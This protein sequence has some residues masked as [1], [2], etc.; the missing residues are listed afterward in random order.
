MTVKNAVRNTN[1]ITGT[2]LLNTVNANVLFHFR[3]TKSFISQDFAHKL[4]LKAEPLK[5]PSHVEVANREVIH[6]SHICTNCE[7]EIEGHRFTLDLIPF[8][9]GE[10]YVI[11][12]MDWLSS[13]K[14][15]IYCK[16]KKVRIK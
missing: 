16:G 5:E 1:L 8:I 11:L 6:A 14:A 13:C 15:S 7:L 3:V 10:F 4:N 9:L 12:G 2:L